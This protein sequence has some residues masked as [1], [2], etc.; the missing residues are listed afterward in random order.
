[1]TPQTE[2][3]P[4]ERAADLALTLLLAMAYGAAVGSGMVIVVSLIALAI[5]L[6][7]GWR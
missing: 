4:I 2:P 1:M 6:L 7:L 3:G 5:G